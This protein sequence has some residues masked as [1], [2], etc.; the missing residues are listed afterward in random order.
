MRE[1]I[2]QMKN[3]ECSEEFI[4]Y[5]SYILYNREIDTTCLIFVSRY[6]VE[7]TTEEGFNINIKD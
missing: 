4:S 6:E 2:K 3:N 5:V 1:I 7:F